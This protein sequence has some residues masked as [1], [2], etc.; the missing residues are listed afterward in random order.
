MDETNYP[1]W[2]KAGAVAIYRGKKVRIDCT[3]P[4][5]FKG[6]LCVQAKTIAKRKTDEEIRI[7]SVDSLSPGEEDRPEKAKAKTKRGTGIC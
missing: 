2:I 1:E 7:Y 6:M 5:M 3:H 4:F